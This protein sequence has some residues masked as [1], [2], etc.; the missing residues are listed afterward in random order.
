MFRLKA[1]YYWIISIILL[2]LAAGSIL[3]IIFGDSSL[4]KFLTFFLTVDLILF[5]I[6]FQISIQK[7]IKF[8][9]RKKNY[10]VKTFKV[11]KN[12]EATLE[13]NKFRFRE[14]DYG[15]SYI[16]IIDK[17]AYKVVLINNVDGYFNAENED[18]NDSE[19]TKRLNNCHKFISLELFDNINQ[20]LQ[21]RIIDFTIQIEKLYITALV[22]NDSDDYVCLNYEIPNE[23]HKENVEKLFNLI[24]LEEKGEGESAK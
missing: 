19:F 24:G 12:I 18:D 6:I 7:S 17:V 4:N 14:R 5:T 20:E 9:E 1:R 2:A 3:G 22:K 13:E 10:I 8:K 16:K 23:N 15:K 21:K 11:T